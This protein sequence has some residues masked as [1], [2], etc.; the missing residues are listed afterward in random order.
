M[1]VNKDLRWLRTTELTDSA[2]RF[3]EFCKTDIHQQAK[4]DPEF[5]IETYS[6]VAKLIIKQLQT[7][8]PPENT[9]KVGK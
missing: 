9:G 8:P 6:E 1:S 5:D 3:T 4:T 7:P 2:K